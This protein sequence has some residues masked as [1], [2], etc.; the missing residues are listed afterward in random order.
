LFHRSARKSEDWQSR[1]A[2]MELFRDYDNAALAFQK[3][4]RPD[5]EFIPLAWLVRIEPDVSGKLRHHPA[6]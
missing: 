5:G 3:E 4:W 1:L 6:V 2:L